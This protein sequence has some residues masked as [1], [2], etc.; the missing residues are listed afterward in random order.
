MDENDLC[1]QPLQYG[2]ERYTAFKVVIKDQD[3]LPTTKNQRD[4]Y[5]QKSYT[6]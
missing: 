1:N 6:L 2:N 3:I 4:K 5:G